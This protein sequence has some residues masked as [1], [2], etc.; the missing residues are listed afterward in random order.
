MPTVKNARTTR[1]NKV[2][3]VVLCGRRDSY[4]DSHRY[5]RTDSSN[6]F[7]PVMQVARPRAAAPDCVMR[8]TASTA[9][10]VGSLGRLPHSKLRSPYFLSLK[11]M[12]REHAGCTSIF[13][14]KQY[15]PPR[16]ALPQ[17]PGVAVRTP[18]KH[19]QKTSAFNPLPADYLR[20]KVGNI[21]LS[22]PAA[23]RS[24]TVVRKWS[25][26]H[27]RHKAVL[28]AVLGRAAGRVPLTEGNRAPSCPRIS[29]FAGLGSRIG[30][31]SKQR[32][33]EYRKDPE[34][35]AIGVTNLPRREMTRGPSAVHRPRR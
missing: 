15:E 26:F 34:E 13:F 14:H 23:G 4:R 12:S 3:Q 25:I 35:I 16:S 31:P 1:A 32:I 21:E 22:R 7:W 2:E 29:H 24:R 8:N 30:G 33:C 28:I 11:P 17:P 20:L 5:T 18:L 9:T 6:R 19:T 10:H 27:T